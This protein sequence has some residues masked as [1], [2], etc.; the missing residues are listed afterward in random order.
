MSFNS[1]TIAPKFRLTKK[2]FYSWEMI[3]VYIFIAINLLLMIFAGDIYFSAGT[4]QTII[5][6]GMEISIMVLGMTLILIL[7]EIDVSVASIMVLS[8][9]IMGLS[10]KAGV[11]TP[12]VI[13]FGMITGGLCGCV[14]G[15]LVTKVKM[16]SVI[17]TIATSMFFRGIAH[18]ILQNGY[19]DSFPAFFSKIAWN[20]IGGVIPVSLVIF[21][22]FAVFFMF[23]LHRSKFGRELYLIGSNKRSADYSGIRVDRT[24]IIAYIIMGITAALS[25]CIFVGRLSGIT[26][27]M[28]TGY[29]L[30]VIAIVVLGG[31][32]TL[33]GKGKLY[34]PVISTFIMAFLAKALDL[35]EIQ[36]NAQKL[37]TGIILIIAVLIPRIN[38]ESYRQFKLKFKRKNLRIIEGVDMPEN[39][40]KAKNTVKRNDIS[41]EYDEFLAFINRF[42]LTSAP[43]DY[44]YKKETLVYYRKLYFEAL[45]KYL[46]VMPWKRLEKAKVRDDLNVAKERYGV[47]L[48]RY[49][50][51]NDAIRIGRKTKVMLMKLSASK[52]KALIKEAYKKAYEYV[53][54]NEIIFNNNNEI[55][56][57][58]NNIKISNLNI[59]KYLNQ[60]N[61]IT[62]KERYE[63]ADES[64]REQL[65]TEY[66]YAEIF[67]TI[68]AYKQNRR[69]NCIS[70]IKVHNITKLK[71]KKN[72]IYKK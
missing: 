45:K 35:F 40:E 62:Y 46:K 32:S 58:V 53:Y 41:L 25:G 33:G 66:K 10:Y 64:I 70:N 47:S 23:L 67:Y 54:N 44:K 3:L 49:H 1:N 65:Y 31:V 63:R 50:L 14:N 48:D 2:F 15:L 69:D 72:E 71:E 16:P 57:Y 38:K 30:K 17:A 4:F 19:L 42:E 9:V 13:L 18:G 7:G 68:L 36:T 20:D 28:A 59:T 21:L 51:K 22:I 56:T 5:R 52:Q 29:E 61:V 24:K 55:V 11:P 8:C 6:S 39:I 12:F 27:S 34:G 26:Y 43:I 37:V 60:D